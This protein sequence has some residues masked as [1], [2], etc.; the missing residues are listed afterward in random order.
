MCTYVLSEE[1][2]ALGS[3]QEK[4]CIHILSG[5]IK[6]G[7]KIS[8]HHGQITNSDPSKYMWP[9]YT[10]TIAMIVVLI[11]NKYTVPEFLDVL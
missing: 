9:S 11:T 5:V 10:I 2:F 8:H 4:V 6:C 3:S 7:W 1:V